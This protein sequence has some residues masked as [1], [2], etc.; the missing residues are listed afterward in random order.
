[1]HFHISLQGTSSTGSGG[2]GN[3]AQQTQQPEYDCDQAYLDDL[4]GSLD[5]FPPVGGGGGCGGGGGQ[6]SSAGGSGRPGSAGSSG[7]AG[8][9]AQN[10]VMLSNKAVREILELNTTQLPDDGSEEESTVAAAASNPHDI[11]DTTT[12]WK[13]KMLPSN[14]EITHR[15]K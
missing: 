9:G 11:C 7:G 10:S 6:P 8:S 1:M 5:D 4:V 15:F 14:I 12:E 13:V 3:V 2:G